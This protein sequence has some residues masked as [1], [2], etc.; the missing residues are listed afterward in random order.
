MVRNKK[1]EDFVVYSSNLDE[2]L[3]ITNFPDDEMDIVLEKIQN[4]VSTPE[5]T[6]RDY[7][8][9]VVES[10]VR[11]HT[12]YVVGSK[13]DETYDALFEAVLEAYPVFQID[14]VW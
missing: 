4:L 8:C 11:N 7:I 2:F 13:D 1:L 6:I 9:L 5:N 10:V 3:R 12:R 14:S